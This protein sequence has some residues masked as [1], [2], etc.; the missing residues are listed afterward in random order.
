[1]KGKSRDVASTLA[2]SEF[3]H[4]IM[5]PVRQFLVEKMTGELN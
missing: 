1:M 3:S 2:N 5:G 4:A